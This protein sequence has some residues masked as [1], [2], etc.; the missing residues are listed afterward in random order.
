[1][2]E[3]RTIKI[4]CQSDNK[5]KNKLEVDYLDDIVG[6]VKKILSLEGEYMYLLLAI[7]KDSS[8]HDDMLFSYRDNKIQV[9]RKCGMYYNSVIP[10]AIKNGR[11]DTLSEADIKWYKEEYSK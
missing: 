5:I 6:Y 11:E 7:D 4:R 9:K 2:P 3:Y 10:W 1:M 8:V